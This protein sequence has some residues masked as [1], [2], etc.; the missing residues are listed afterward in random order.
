MSKVQQEEI[1]GLREDMRRMLLEN[2]NLKQRMVTLQDEI[3]ILLKQQ[4]NS[5]A[6][7]S[8][9][10]EAM[11]LTHNETLMRELQNLRDASSQSSR[12]MQ[13]HQQQQIA[14]TL[15]ARVA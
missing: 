10:V 4:V 7:H 2:E 8:E 3:M 15:Q 6:G 12:M 5:S 9:S 11:L 14:Q 1:T 13:T